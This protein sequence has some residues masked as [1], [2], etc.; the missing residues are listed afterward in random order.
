MTLEIEQYFSDKNDD[1]A[2]WFEPIVNGKEI[3]MEFLLHG[4]NSNAAMKADDRYRFLRDI[5]SRFKDDTTREDMLLKAEAER[6]ANCISDIRG[7]DGRKLLVGGKEM[8]IK[9]LKDILYK[10]PS[11]LKSIDVYYRTFTKSFAIDE[12]LLES[13]VRN[14]FY[15]NHQYA[16]H[17]T[18]TNAKT[19][20][21]ESKTRYV[22]NIDRRDDF[23]K[24]FGEE[25][26]E[27][28]CITDE[29][30]AKLKSVQIPDGCRWL[31]GH[32]LEIWYLCSYDFGGN[33][34]FTTRDIIDYCECFGVNIGYYDRHVIMKMKSWAMSEIALLGKEEEK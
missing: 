1:G 8:S 5:A 15:L 25:A 7:K 14:Y 30:W 29:K 12:E 16:E 4:P 28:V 18:V 9:D 26:F 31:F 27:E 10:S 11:I 34:V 2:V 21:K 33:R 3:G 22:R 19:K 32:F 23:I 20:G 24:K 17:Y 6:Y 13:A